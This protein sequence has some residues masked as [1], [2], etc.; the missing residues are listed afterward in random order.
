MMDRQQETQ[1]ILEFLDLALAHQGGRAF[2]KKFLTEFPFLGMTDMTETVT[3]ETL[4]FHEGK[5]SAGVVLYTALFAANANGLTS[6]LQEMC[7]DQ[8]KRNS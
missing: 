7:H 6:L 8:P 2:L 1:A 3:P 5:R 4:A